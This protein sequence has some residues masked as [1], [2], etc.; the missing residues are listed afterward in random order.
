MRASNELYIQDERV[1][2]YDIM[3]FQ[4][5]RKDKN[6]EHNIYSKRC[7]YNNTSDKINV[8]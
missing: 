7:H 1:N 8:I 2:F 4:N 6:E 5:L 3:N